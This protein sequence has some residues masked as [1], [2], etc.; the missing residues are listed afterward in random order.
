MTLPFKQRHS[1][2]FPTIQQVHH[3][4]IRLSKY[5]CT[6]SL[7]AAAFVLL[8]ANCTV[9]DDSAKPL[10]TQTGTPPT[11]EKAAETIKVPKG[12]QVTLFAG[13]PDVQQPIAITTDA[14]G[15]LW[16]AENYTYAE[17]P[18][19]FDNRL[20]DRIIILEDTNQD[21]KFDVRKVFWDGAKKL[22]SVEI[23]HGGVWAL[24][25][26]Q[27]LF[28][29]DRNHDDIPDGPAEVVLDGWNEHNIRHNIVNGLKWGPDGWLYGRHGILAT[30][31]VGPPGSSSSQRRKIN[32]GIWRYHPTRKIFEVVAHGTTNSWGFD[33]N[34]H[35]QMFFINTVIGH[36]WHLV[37]GAH[38]RRMYGADFNPHLYELIDQCADHVHWDTGEKW[39]DI[40]QGVSDTTSRAGGGHA[41]SGLM[42]YLGD[43][44]PDDYRDSILTLNF[45]G[46]R[47]N[48]DHLLR[49]QAGYVGKHGKDFFF[50]NNEWFRGL[51][52]IYGADGGVYVADWSDTG[53]CH[54]NDGI[55]RTSGRIYKLTYGPPQRTGPTDLSKLDNRELV[56]LQLHKNDWYVRQSRQLL[57]ARSVS[58]QDMSQPRDA[59]L[60][61]YK[62]NP[63]VTRQ[64]RA[65]WCL[66]LI[67]GA[68]DH[69]LQ[70]QLNHANEHIRVW[71][72]RL[73]ADGDDVS[74]ETIARFAK[75]TTTEPSGLV[76]LFLASALQRLPMSDRWTVAEELVSHAKDTADRALP[77]MIWY[78]IEPA[79]PTDPQRAVA[80]AERSKIPLVRRHIVRRLTSDL[81]SHPRP[82]EHLLQL[83]GTRNDPDF[84]LDILRG[85][86]QALRGWR[87]APTPKAWSRAAEIVFT[88]SPEAVKAEA[89]Q[90]G[91]VFGDGR[92]I[93]E[94]HNIV[95][96][97]KA[98][99]ESRRS[100]L[101]SLID[102]RVPQTLTILKQL[103]GDR[104]LMN[105]VL[106]GFAAFDDPAIPNLILSRYARLSP[107]SRAT[108][109]DT[110]TS[111]PASAKAL[112]KAIDAGTIDRSVISAY[113][114]RQMRSFKDESVNR[115]LTRLW[116][117]IR[118]T[119]QEKKARIAQL[120]AKLT[121][122]HLALGDASQGRRLFEKTCGNCHILY[123]KG[124]RVG[125]DLTG[126]NRHNLAYLL[127]NIIDPSASVNQAFKV[128]V[129]VL[130][131]GRIVTGV[132]VT[133]TDRTTTI[134][135]QKEQLVLNRSDIDEVVQ[136]DV[137]LMPDGLLK[138]LTDE[139]IRDL[140]TYLSTRT[141]VPISA[142]D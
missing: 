33:Y 115:D 26:P 48:H 90:L 97:K 35:G 1:L 76:R 50:A 18:V 120:Q 134:Q 61:I 38:Y 24:C 93:A 121:A 66:H 67:G 109:I 82:I 127:E 63:D 59:L 34:D 138:Q 6:A 106:R 99:V 72:V 64:L 78:G 54:E 114:A 41:H 56:K 5:A 52:L 113:H 107:I 104:T 102:E 69:W 111:R 124:G 45:H 49:H 58:G 14:R 136:Q 19:G 91:I 119:S 142:K 139:Q 137:S 126:S 108:A 47:I 73:L 123:G 132:V 57:Y 117:S 37:P 118:N 32:C 40:R 116:G 141:Q 22:T 11:A 125:P 29:P 110:L 10:N 86:N 53:E 133:K 30:S 17:Q 25:T 92:A 68:N 71:A 122:E 100:A 27:L 2:T 7:I 51:D 3:S 16:V 13:E 98:D 8:S 88:T 94:L 80:L 28:I 42:I 12:F 55:H 46:R 83:I 103:L 140:F 75:M 31:V 135:T 74:S 79:V 62:K 89:R 130:N 39:S 131:D 20:N 87:K 36:L 9:G 85:M 112:L 128:S 23:G 96:D 70:E 101:R 4:V 105:E 129:I 65:L 43:N 84:Q 21:G 60:A 44:W 95:T 77:L 15:R 81:E